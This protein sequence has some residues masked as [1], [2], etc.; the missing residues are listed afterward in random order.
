MEYEKEPRE[1]EDDMDPKSRRREGACTTGSDAEFL[2]EASS[3]N[4]RGSA[5]LVDGIDEFPMCEREGY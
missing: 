5:G 2:K 4:R 3:R 1:I